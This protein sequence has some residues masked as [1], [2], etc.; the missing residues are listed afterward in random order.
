LDE[1]DFDELFAMFND[2]LVMR[3]YPGLKNRDETR[4]WL[5]R[6]LKGYEEFGHGLWAVRLRSSGE[7]LGQIGLLRQMVDGAAETEVAYLLKSAHWGKGY[8]TEAAMKSRDYGFETLGREHLISLIRPVNT[9]SRAVA[10]RLGMQVW[11]KTE[12]V[13][14]EHLVYRIDATP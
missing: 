4:T 14:W 5:Q 1:G 9:P 12:R 7:F 3:Y 2:P 10:E 11:K 6:Q 13:G 8:A